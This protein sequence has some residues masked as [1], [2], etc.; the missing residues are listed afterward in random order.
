[1]LGPGH[2]ASFFILLMGQGAPLLLR[3]KSPPNHHTPPTITITT[4]GARGTASGRLP[5][6]T[7]RSTAHRILRDDLIKHFFCRL[8]LFT[9]FSIPMP[10]HFYLHGTSA[11]PALFSEAARPCPS[12]T[13][14]PSWPVSDDE[15]HLGS[16]AT[17]SAERY[18]SVAT[19]K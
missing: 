17:H 8:G 6:H 14:R 7:R 18:R 9:E 5:A 3:I 12:R 13:V 15:R 11:K 4:R 16:Y 19:C 2:L 1:M 10:S